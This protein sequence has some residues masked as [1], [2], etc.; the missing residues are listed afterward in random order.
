M[1]GI[2]TAV[3]TTANVIGT[4]MKSDSSDPKQIALNVLDTYNSKNGQLLRTDG[5][6][7]SLLGS[8][9]VEPV[10]IV[11]NNA[12]VVD[13]A[14]RALEL[15]MDM[16]SAFYLQA[17]EILRSVYGLDTKVIINALG[18][19]NAKTLDYILQTAR[20]QI[21]SED[22]KL[23]KSF[24]DSFITSDTLSFSMEDSDDNTV[25]KAILEKLKELE[26]LRASQKVDQTDKKATL[27]AS[28][29]AAGKDFKDQATYV[30]LQR[31][32][33]VTVPLN[34]ETKDTN[35]SKSIIRH[36]VIIP[37]T[38]KAH[39]LFTSID[40][41]LTM[42]APFNA[43]KSFWSRWDDW[44]SGA[45]SGWDLV[46]C[47]DLIKKYKENK[48]NDKA[49]L[50]SLLMDRSISANA[51]VATNKFVGFEKFYNMLVITAEDKIRIDKAVSGNI[52]EEKYKQ[53]L[54]D[55]TKALTCTIL[56]TDYE[57]VIILT[58]DIRG[59]TN[60]S[61]KALARRKENNVDLSEILKSI[62]ANKPP[63][64]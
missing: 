31:N 48:F 57:R 25:N 21:S 39:V 45:I 24:V 12:K 64:F 13:V 49:G 2:I 1:S 58:K 22:F 10:F 14:D 32:I 33:E 34:F 15:N 46:F 61:F 51:K 37:I 52:E 36:N 62:M 18:T 42:L 9:I 63:V 3:A 26:K 4:V 54:L 11:S 5:S 27:N 44:R 28:A 41:I 53:R 17:F 29:S 43:D 16:F 8:Y 50:L 40:N 60:L 35:G 23:P 30:L 7:T 20:T 6:I 56:D 55:Q 47:G 38:I 59:E 19:D